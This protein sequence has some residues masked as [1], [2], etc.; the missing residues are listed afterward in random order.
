MSSSIVFW[1]LLCAWMDAQALQMFGGLW[2]RISLQTLE[3]GEY[4]VDASEM[5]FNSLYESLWFQRWE[6]FVVGVYGS[7]WYEEW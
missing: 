5:R 7:I 3:L 1:R 6:F 2:S 4:S